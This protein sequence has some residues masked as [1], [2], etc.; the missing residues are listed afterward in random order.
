MI[1]ITAAAAIAVL[2]NPGITA[3][4]SA[5][6][7]RADFL[8]LHHLTWPEAT[9]IAV[10][11]LQA[12]EEHDLPVSLVLAI[13][14]TESA[15]GRQERS[16]AK[17][18]GLMQ[19][20]PRTA[21]ALAHKAGIR[22]Y[23]LV[24]IEPNIRLGSMYLKELADS[25]NGKMAWALTAYNRGPGLFKKQRFRVSDYARTVLRKAEIIKTDLKG[26]GPYGMN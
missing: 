19:L 15:Y 2:T 20:A 14:E 12:A 16:V 22:H 24:D 26:R 5:V 10:A 21:A 9:R 11:A 8:E 18:V 3:V 23:R 6:D 4:A 25:Y 13:I 1:A 7:A 17:C